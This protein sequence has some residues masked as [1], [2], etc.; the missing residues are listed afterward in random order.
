MNIQMLMKE[1]GNFVNMATSEF[2]IYVT[3]RSINSSYVS[4]SIFFSHLEQQY[5][6]PKQA[7]FLELVRIAQDLPYLCRIPHFLSLPRFQ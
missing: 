3:Q 6:F 7:T 2:F 1:S 5:F 4:R